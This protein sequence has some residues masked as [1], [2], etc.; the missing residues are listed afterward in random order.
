MKL[1]KEEQEV[2]DICSSLRERKKTAKAK[3]TQKIRIGGPYTSPRMAEAF[4]A[5]STKVGISKTDIL[6][7]LLSKLLRVN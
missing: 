5:F 2:V 1:S 3:S 7:G 4:E 6:E